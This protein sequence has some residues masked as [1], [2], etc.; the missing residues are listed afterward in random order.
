[1][2]NEALI[3][4]EAAQSLSLLAQFCEDVMARGDVFDPRRLTWLIDTRSEQLIA[5]TDTLCLA[6]R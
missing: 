3:E 6:L 4:S 1:M 2:V 5:L